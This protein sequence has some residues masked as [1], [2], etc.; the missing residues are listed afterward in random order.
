ML[1]NELDRCSMNARKKPSDLKA[2]L[3]L[4]LISSILFLPVMS[5]GAS[6]EEWDINRVVEIGLAYSPKLTG[7]QQT[8]KGA[9]A[10][11]E[12]SL[13]SYYPSL[14]LQMDYTRL[15]GTSSSN[16]NPFALSNGA[17]DFYTSSFVLSQNIYDFGRRKYRVEASRYDVKTLQWDFRDVRLAVIDAIKESYYGV[18]LADRTIKVR[19]D[20]LE[21]TKEHLRQAETFFKVG[22]RP[23]IDVTQ[24]EVAVIT[25]QKAL[26]QAQNDARVGR[27]VLLQNMGLG[28]A[29]V[30]SLKDDL[31]VGRVNWQLEDLKKETLRNNPIL[32]RL[33][34]AISSTEA[35]EKLAQS[36]YWPFLDGT[37]NYGWTGS[38][39]PPSDSTWNFGV[40]LTFPLFA[41]FQTRG[42]V[43]EA[44]ALLGQAKA[45][46]D[47]QTLEVLGN[48][49]N[50]YLSLLLAEKQIEVATEAL[51]SARE[52]FSLSTGR[53]KAGVG[54]ML[55]VSDAQVSLAQS[56]TDHIQALFNYKIACFRLERIVGR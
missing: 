24:A 49:E 5:W 36:D 31:E 54:T 6:I 17:R 7:A 33:Q 38:S 18:L 44:R 16:A 15:Q 22:T 30:F 51:R 11:V 1:T 55:E 27:V 12:Q 14:A 41:G 46:F 23:K 8:V 37:A 21:R 32:N 3:V 29:P 53:Y 2:Q 28:S 20:D 43:S 9:E 4:L 52:N 34:S 40:Q 13:S 26:L 25:A 35:Q 48:L 39:Y 45:T 42:K 10:R 56:E 19:Q 47:E 50:Q